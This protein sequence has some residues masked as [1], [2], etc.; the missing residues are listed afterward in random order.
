[1][2]GTGGAASGGMGG[3]T[4]G[5]SGTGG[6]SED[7]SGGAAAVGGGDSS[8][9]TGGTAGTGGASGNGSGGAGGTGASSGSGGAAG[10]GAAASYS[11]CTFIG[12]IDRVVVA[13]LDAT[14][15]LCFSLVLMNAGSGQAPTPGLALPEGW[16]LERATAGPGS[17]CPARFGAVAA[18][19]VTGNV[20]WADT[21][22]VFPGYPNHVDLDVLLS[23]PA[24][25]AGAGGS[26][27]LNAANVDVQ[28]GCG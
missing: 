21:G 13:K 7:A 23:F 4:A 16:R 17:D 11:G 19:A 27:R 18:S 22:S 28:G 1:M 14:R 15:G 10:A 5:S 2:A 24:D 8:A 3:S 25:D 6:S 26:E 20:R 12:A 9:G